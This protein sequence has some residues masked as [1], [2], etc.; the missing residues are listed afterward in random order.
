MVPRPGLWAAHGNVDLVAAVGAQR[1]R[2][3]VIA[4]LG[5]DPTWQHHGDLQVGAAELLWDDG[6]QH[7]VGR[8]QR[9]GKARFHDAPQVIVLHG[10]E[11]IV[12]RRVIDVGRQDVE[13]AEV[14]RI[15]DRTQHHGVIV[16]HRCGPGQ[17]VV[18][19]H[20]GHAGFGASVPWV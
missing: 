18:L 7:V 20:T 9:S 13:E 2:N 3:A 16:A 11:E 10:G 12:D 4:R 5:D 19:V 14:D 1:Q 15:A 6:V 8:V 17:A